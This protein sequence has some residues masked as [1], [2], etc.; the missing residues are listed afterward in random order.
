M[1]AT[2]TPPGAGSAGEE[3]ALTFEGCHT[4]EELLLAQ[5]KK[6]RISQAVA[7]AAIKDAG[8]EP[9]TPLSDEQRRRAEVVEATKGGLVGKARAQWI[10]TGDSGGAAA[11]NGSAKTSGRK[12]RAGSRA[13]SGSRGPREGSTMHSVLRILKAKRKAMTPEEMYEEMKRLGIAGNLRGKTPVAT[14]AAQC[15]TALG[16]RQHGITRPEKGKYEVAK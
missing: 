2:R 8:L 3:P 11:S 15:S 6:A 5:P 16:K 14:I 12:A 1:T 9:E 4:I 7:L 13:D 10:V